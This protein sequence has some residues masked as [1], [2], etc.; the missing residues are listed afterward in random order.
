MILGSGLLGAAQAGVYALLCDVR[1][2]LHLVLFWL[3]GL[4]FRLSLYTIRPSSTPRTL[5]VFPFPSDPGPVGTSC[6]SS[7][8]GLWWVTFP[9]FTRRL[10]LLLGALRAP[11]GLRPLPGTPNRQVSS[12]LPFMP[13]TIHWDAQGMQHV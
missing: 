13:C 2:R 12:T 1:V 4:F 11:P 7:H 9:P 3:A 5:W 8:A 6:L 10:H